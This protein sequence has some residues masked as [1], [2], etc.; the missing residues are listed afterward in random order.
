MWGAQ[1]LGYVRIGC[2]FITESWRKSAEIRDVNS[3]GPWF[4]FVFSCCSTFI[5]N[6]WKLDCKLEYLNYLIP[7]LLINMLQFS[8]LVSFN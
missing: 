3:P 1:R 7:A 8:T 4:G 2:Q 6:Y 5:E